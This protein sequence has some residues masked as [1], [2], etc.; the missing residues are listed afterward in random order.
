MTPME[1]R[2]CRQAASR[3]YPLIST[4]PPLFT[5]SPAKILISVD[6]PAPFGPS[7]PKIDPLGISRLT[8]LSARMAG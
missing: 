8:P 1:S 7:S 2:A 6:F 3:S 4:W 5:T